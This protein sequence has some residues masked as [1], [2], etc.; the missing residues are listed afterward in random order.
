MENNAGFWRR[1]LAYTVDILPITLI[2]ATVFHLFFGLDEAFRNQ[3]AA[4]RDLDTR[5][6]LYRVRN[7]AR[8][9]TFAIWVLYCIVFEWS[10]LQGTL[11]KL[12]VGIKVVDRNGNRLSLD[13]SIGR[14]LFKFVSLLVLGLGF[15][16]AAFTRHKQGWHDLVAKTYVVKRRQP[17]LEPP[18]TSEWGF[19]PR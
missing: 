3:I 19:P 10:P 9:L 7:Q 12:L 11:G 8:D 15:I 5:L 17:Q 1:T 16:W 2:V 14:N 4:P 6:E 18:T 13:R